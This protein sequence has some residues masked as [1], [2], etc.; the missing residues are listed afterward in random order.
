VLSRG[1]LSGGRNEE[2]IAFYNNLINELLAAG[3]IPVV[4]LSHW[5]IPQGLDDEYGG[6]L[7]PEI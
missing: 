4:T 2:G 5:D 1:K 6:F 7:S 3:I